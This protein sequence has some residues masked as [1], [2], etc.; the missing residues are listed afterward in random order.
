MCGEPETGEGGEGWHSYFV[1]EER[2]D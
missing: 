2:A 1:L